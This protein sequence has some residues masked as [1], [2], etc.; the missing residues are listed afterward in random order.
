M[1]LMSGIFPSVKT[2][3]DQAATVIVLGAVLAI[4]LYILIAFLKGVRDERAQRRS[5]KVTSAHAD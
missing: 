1:K 3:T 2:I 5:S 4:S